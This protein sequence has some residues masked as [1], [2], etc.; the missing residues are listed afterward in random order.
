MPT[1]ARNRQLATVV[2]AAVT[3]GAALVTLGDRAGIVVLLALGLAQ[4]IAGGVLALAGHRRNEA[5]LLLIGG[6]LALIGLGLLLAGVA[7]L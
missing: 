7:E 4:T 5:P 1:P 3:F 6:I 2:V